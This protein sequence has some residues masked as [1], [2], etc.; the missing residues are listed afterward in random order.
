MFV[1]AADIGGVSVETLDG[2]GVGD[3]ASDVAATHPGAETRDSF[4]G[5]ERQWFTI[6]DVNLGVSPD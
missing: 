3:S 4:D 5:V 6:G 2:I 1:T